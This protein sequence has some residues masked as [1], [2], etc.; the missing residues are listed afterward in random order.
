MGGYK[1]IFSTNNIL[2]YLC[3]ENKTIALVRCRHALVVY[4]NKNIEQQSSS[5]LR[6][7]FDT[8]LKIMPRKTHHFVNTS[9]ESEWFKLK[10]NLQSKIKRDD[11]MGSL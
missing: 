9:K 8:Y 7:T 3:W 6:T 10:L 2:F 11:C 4:S 5:N 1:F